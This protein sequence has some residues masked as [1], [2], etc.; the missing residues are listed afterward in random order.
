MAQWDSL[1]WVSAAALQAGVGPR[2][3]L[4]SC[5]GP[6]L[7]WQDSGP[8]HP[9]TSSCLA[10]GRWCLVITADPTGAPAL[11]Q[12]VLTLLSLSC[13]AFLDDDTASELRS[14]D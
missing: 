4:F 6:P 13:L 2:E 9:S 3:A 8:A 10:R 7:T 12:H 14:L 11:R 5:L 1:A